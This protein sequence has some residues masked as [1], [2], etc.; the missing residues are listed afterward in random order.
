MEYAKPQK[1]PDGRYFLKVSAGGAP[2]RH[3]V[4]GLVLQDSLESKSVNFK[5]EDPKI[6]NDIDAE[7]LAKAKDSARKAVINGAAS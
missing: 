2:V 6:F 5:I 4:N 7:L 3:Q 1:L